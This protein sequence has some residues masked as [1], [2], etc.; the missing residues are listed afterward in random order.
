M[1]KLF[2]SLAYKYVMLTLMLAE[3]NHTLDTLEIHNVAPIATT[4]I[5]S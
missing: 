2:I 5:I 3:A 4:N 1:E